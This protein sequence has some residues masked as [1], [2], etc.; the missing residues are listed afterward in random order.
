ME[1]TSLREHE[2]QGSLDLSGAIGYL[3]KVS[4]YISRVLD[5]VTNI[6]L[7]CGFNVRLHP[8]S[9]QRPHDV[10]NVHSGF[11][12]SSEYRNFGYSGLK[13]P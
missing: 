12:R 5:G 1:T 4:T 2:I 7:S 3:G 11:Y 10:C 13:L 9:R 6:E 8:N